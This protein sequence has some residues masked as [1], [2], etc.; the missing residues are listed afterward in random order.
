MVRAGAIA[1]RVLEELTALGINTTTGSAGTPEATAALVAFQGRVLSDYYTEGK[2]SGLS[3]QDRLDNF[4]LVTTTAPMIQ[5]PTAGNHYAPANSLLKG[6]VTAHDD[7]MAPLALNPCGFPIDFSPLDYALDG[8]N[9]V[10][11]NDEYGGEFPWDDRYFG[12]PATGK[13]D[14]TCKCAPLWFASRAIMVS[15]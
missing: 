6:S 7:G 1:K 2:G 4:T 10:L 3:F 9:M 11:W 15:I 12:S 14:P 13:F 5:A 8:G